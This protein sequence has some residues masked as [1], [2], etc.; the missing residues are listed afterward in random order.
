MKIQIDETIDV[1][2]VTAER[3]AAQSMNQGFNGTRPQRVRKAL[4]V[5]IINE[6]VAAKFRIG[7]YGEPWAD[8]GL[9]EYPRGTPREIPPRTATICVECRHHVYTMPRGG[10]PG[11]G[12]GMTANEHLCSHPSVRREA[13]VDVVTGETAYRPGGPGGMAVPE[14]M[15]TCRDVNDGRC[16][17]YE[18]KD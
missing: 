16:K 3:L 4:C 17:L 12:P 7:K 11:Y 8:V 15:P 18:T 6:C 2:E 14:P 10:S 1:D 9:V 13:I 5:A